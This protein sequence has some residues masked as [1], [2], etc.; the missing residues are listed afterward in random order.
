MVGSAV[1]ESGC[2]DIWGI[3]YWVAKTADFED[4]CSENYSAG[5]AVGVGLDGGRMFPAIFR[6]ELN[7][8]R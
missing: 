3:V 4:D 1:L 8:A 6:S 2:D 5:L 7:W